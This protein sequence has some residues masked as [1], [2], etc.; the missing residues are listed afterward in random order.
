MTSERIISLSDYHRL[1]QTDLPDD[2]YRRQLEV[3]CN[4]A[5]LALFIMDEHQQC[6]YMNPAAEA[7]TGYTLSE[8]KGRTLHDV[9]HHTRPD[10]RPYPLC[11]CPIDQAFPTN[12]REQGEEVFVHK[13]GHFYPV[14]YT[15]SPIREGDRPIGTI[16]E[17]RDIT[18]EK[19][20][21]Q[22]QQASLYREQALRAEV[23]ASHQQIAQS[24]ERL[25]LALTAAQL[26][27]WNW[28]AKTDIVTF[29]DRGAA[30]FGISP[31]ALI[32]WTQIQSL[33]HSADR[34]R[35]RLAVEAAILQKSDYDIEYRVIHPD[36]RERWIS[37]M[38]RG[39]YD[40]NGNILGMHG[41]VQDITNR[42]QVEE[43][44]RE[45]NVQLESA[46][47]A[48]LI[49]TWR[50]N[51]RNNRV[52][53]ST[54]LVH[55]FGVDPVQAVHGLP[56]ETFVNAMHPADRLRVSE[57][58]QQ[59]IA[60][61]EEYQAEYRVQTATGKE[62]WVMAR[63][64]VEY[65]ADGNPIAF[66][67]ALADI[68]E[69]K[70]SEEALQQALQKLNFHVENTPMAVVEWNEKFE[71]TRWSGAAELIF[72]WQAD[73]VLGKSLTELQLVFA[74]DLE[75]V[76]EVCNRLRLGE[77]P[78]I[79]SYN[80]NYTKHGGIVHC[81]WYNSSLRDA[82]GQ[83]LSVLS[84]VLDI[85]AKKQ[86]EA[87]RD[88]L[89]QQER[90]ARETAETAN[91]IKDEFLAVLSHEL[92]SPLN[93]ILGW[94]KLLQSGRLD[95]AKTQQALA[96]I[97]RNAKLQAELIEDLLDV[98]RILQG[99][100]SLNATVVDLTAT[101][102]LA[103]ETV[104]LAAEAK[105]IALH[106]QLE[107]NIGQVIGDSSRLQQVV[108]N[109]LSNAIKFTPQGGRV[110]VELAR[111]GD[112]AQITISDTGKGISPEFLPHVFDYFRQENAST[113]RKFGG[114]GLG[115]AIV[116]HLVE[117]HGGTVQAD[118]PGEGQGATFS[119]YLPIKLNS[120][121]GSQTSQPQE[122]TCNL[123][124]IKILVVDDDTDTREF[125]AFLLEQ[126][127]ATVMMVGSAFA[128]LTAVSQFQPDV[129]LSDI[130]M[131]EMDG[132][133]LMQQI[134]ALPPHQ[135]GKV[136]A[137]ALS[138]YAGEIDYQRAV[139]VGFQQHHAKP[140]EPETLMKAIATLAY[141]HAINPNLQNL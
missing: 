13:D 15:A 3:I 42:K 91:R 4:N 81:E 124:G 86:A 114:L 84:L 116:R 137:I 18:Q 113:T 74:E 132:Y 128:A 107:A 48:G 36:S 40:S 135:G 76:T 112:L 121:P 50:W 2:F 24:A 101:I 80:R 46:L 93:P 71:I 19:L 32:T 14:A 130:G 26:G 125:L 77:E 138:A 98:S 57:S 11:E 43:E 22:A 30:I 47:G 16:I 29:S 31:G 55:L 99:K 126:S 129:L 52:T 8:T 139:A 5:T 44:L 70:R 134:R 73:E 39:Y 82:S 23:E 87:E 54:N 45:A 110:S 64:L 102:R 79:F 95:P 122:P 38:G 34:D 92:R 25:N 7:L 37:A 6:V 28:D 127:G 96:T 115:L 68:T 100:L 20:A 62:R 67:G 123:N 136:P 35:A 78:Y 69:R 58:I 104:Q 131:P 21:E 9:I 51:I 105:A 94:S 66:P 108:W 75:E 17:V 140:V 12:N 118:S 72:G 119:V 90:A 111:V 85:T 103:I 106:T 56:I 33:L 1:P 141:E 10:G 120:T 89:L 27:T 83:M 63:G 53:G 88:R 59:A 60:T 65:D 61:G 117:L 41:V 97:E 133:Q 49:Y 109:L